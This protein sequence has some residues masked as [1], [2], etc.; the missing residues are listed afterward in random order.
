MRE[1]LGLCSAYSLLY[2]VRRPED[3]IQAA[4]ICGT[5]TLS[6]TDRDNLY[7]LPVILEKSKE[8][9][10]RPIIGACLTVPGK[11]A[12]YCFVKDRQGYSRLC[13]ILTMRNRDKE[14]YKPVS[15]LR[16]DAAGL[17]LASSDEV[18]LEA[19]AGRSQS[20]YAAISPD[21]LGA[22]GPS[23]RL[24]VPLAF[25]D[26]ALFLEKEDYPIH[27]VLRAIDLGKTVGNLSEG[28]TVKKD[29]HLLLSDSVLAGRLSSWPEAVKGTKEISAACVYH[30]LFEDWIFPGYTT[31]TTPGDELYKRVLEGAAARYGELGDAEL[32]RIDYELGIINS[33][34][35]APY[36]LVMDDIVRMASRTCGRGSGAAS[37]VSYSL[38]I[39]NVDPLR[40]HLYFERFLNPARPDPPDIDVDF[41]WDERDDLIKRVIERFG[42]DRCARVA[43]HNMF[44]P[45]SA[46]REAAKAYGF[47]DAEISQIEKQLFHFGD[48]S[49]VS[50]PLWLEILDI[51]KKIEG[52]PRGLSMHCG[53]LVI[54]PERIDRYVPIENSLDGYP[55]LSWEKDG[56]EASGFVKIDLLG[57]RSLAVIRDALSNLEEQGIS[58]DRDTWR[59]VED[60][61]TVAALARGDSM[62]VFYIESPAMRQLQKKTG[63]GDFEHIVIHSSIIRPAAN[64]F[65]N[66]YVRRLKGGAWEPLHPRLA[67]I[68]DETYGILCY[69]EDVS[70]TAVALAGFDEV[71]AD[72]LR[73]V[74]A[75]KAEIK[76]AAYEKQF[77][78]GCRKNGVTEDVIQKIWDMMLSFDGY[79]FCK[80]HSASYA[81]VSFQSAYLRVHFPAEFM[82]AV[83]SNQGGYYRPHA[84][85]AECRRMRLRVQ[86]PDV[87]T[88]RWRYYG[89]QDTVVVGFMAVKGLSASGGESI[90]AERERG[91]S[92][93]SLGDFARRVKLGRDDIIALC[94]A[95]IFDNIAEGRERT[96]QARELLKA[97]TGAARRGQD[98]LFAAE[99]APV[100]RF[101]GGAALAPAPVKKKTVNEELWEEY[102]AL[103]FLRNLHPLALWKDKV[104]AVKRV[105]AVH[106]GEYLGRYVCLVGWPITQKE[107]WT[108][109]GLTM[110]FLTF[111]DETALYETVIFPKVYDRYGRL[112]FDQVPLLVYGRVCEDNGAV[113]LEVEKVEGM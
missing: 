86:G 6:F 24:G 108:K 35:F 17:I 66:E 5:D 92:Y 84:Y 109:D 63:A 78:E 3:M 22:I 8:M 113:S 27:R 82:A 15:L 90:I 57:N 98:E 14:N 25:L 103:G 18:I 37:I 89:E 93:K 2:G 59:P 47:G 55:L 80:P 102:R 70:K 72:K 42:K 77:F 83:L 46:F 94:P 67:Y 36:F 101:G 68:L 16:Q 71:E 11:G 19:L 85:V 21:S 4:K 44:R 96:L 38:G 43:N 81:M 13:E 111:E 105:K 64:T 75:K 104:L 107:V 112:L 48:K 97:H 45:R 39:T 30:E 1:R 31:E 29:S 99:V 62:G 20:L 65:I 9:G 69:Q 88:S 79:S 73:K 74:I 34:G 60:G 28:D 50:D 61:P 110:S 40:H 49:G 7:G 56:T 76:L 33:K 52:L 12:V 95:G 32:G 58:I 41:A 10:I 106:I 91:G 54:T 51:A 23:R 26:T 87:N 100:Y 53:G